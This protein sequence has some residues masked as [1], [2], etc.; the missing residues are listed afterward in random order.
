MKLRTYTD[1]EHFLRKTQV[2]LEVQEAANSLMLGICGQLVHHPERFKAAP[3]LKTVEDRTGLILVAVM[4]PPHN[5]LVYGHRGDLGAATGILAQDLIADGWR[6]PGVMGPSEVAKVVAEAWTKATRRELEFKERQRVYELREVVSPVPERGCLRQAKE[7]DA[8]RVA[9]W[10]HGFNT[11]ISGEAD[12][13]RARLAAEQR[14]GA[15]D[16]YLWRDPDPVSMAMKNRPTRNG[17]SVSAVYTP[18]EL[19][20][21]GYATACVGELSRMLLASGWRY[22]ALFADLNNL[23][24]N[25]VYRKVGYRRACDYD[26]YTFREEE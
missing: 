22:C 9:Q 8:D 20:G 3:C 13:D 11:E 2:A 19:R 14:I 1:A 24:A 15:G 7:T 21:R 26:E 17:I 6:V 10:W 5:L 18:P 12:R 16:I 23:S 25:R 4:T